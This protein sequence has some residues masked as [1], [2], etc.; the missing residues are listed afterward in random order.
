MG[1]LSDREKQRECHATILQEA[2]RLSRLVNNVLNFARIEAGRK[3]YHFGPVDLNVV[4]A[5]VLR[6]YS[7]Q[8]ETEGFSTAVDTAEGLPPVRAD[9]EAITEALI[10]ILDNAIKFSGERKHLRV[11]TGRA[12][13][14]LF[15]EVEDRG[16]G[17]SPA[18]HEKVFETF[19]RVPGP[20]RAGIKGSGI[21]LALVRQIMEAHGGSVSLRSRPGEGSAFRM[22]FPEQAPEDAPTR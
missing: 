20:A 11:S 2:E 10:N 13:G 15:V 18:H 1:R 4:V 6:V 7:H 16:I 5:D 22:V 12:A 21:G 14:T 8:L 9:R 3:E 19:F 17:I